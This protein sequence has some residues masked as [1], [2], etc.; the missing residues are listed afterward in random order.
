MLR[1]SVTG[2]VSIEEDDDI[3]DLAGD[4]DYDREERQTQEALLRESLATASN[5]EPDDDVEGWVDEMAA[6]SVADRADL[7]ASIRP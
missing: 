7:E 3:R 5:V 4:L 2:A 1:K 6:L